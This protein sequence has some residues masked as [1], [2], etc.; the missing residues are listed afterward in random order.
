MRTV[1]GFGLGLRREHYAA[2]LADRPAVDWFEILTENYLVP[3]GAPLRNLEQIRARFPLVMHGVS[4]SIGSTAALNRRYLQALKALADRIEPAWI[5]D[6]LC[7]TGVS[8]TNLHD[9]MPLPY[10]EAV[11]RHIVSRLSRVQ[12][13]LR[14]RILLENVSSYLTYRESE[15]T[16]WEFLSEIARRA[17]CDLLLDVNNV[18]VSSINHGF[19]PLRYLSDVPAQ[20]VKQIHLAGHRKWGG[21]LID[22]HDAP[23]AEPVWRLYQFAVSR[24][25]PVPTLIERDDDIPALG[26]LIEELA[27][28]RSI[29]RAVHEAEA[30]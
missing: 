14:R 7:W 16:E 8:G 29:V 9:L 17:D 5:S 27:R 19:D 4:L 24:F 2:I 11:V 23:V 28:A 13:F 26:V 30:A 3:G 25:G 1:S 20:R 10:T 18:Y 15:M 22:T 6:H 21:Y 12:E